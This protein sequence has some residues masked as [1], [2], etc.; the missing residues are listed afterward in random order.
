MSG[1]SEAR[2]TVLYSFLLNLLFQK[3]GKYPPI[4]T[5]PTIQGYNCK[6]SGIPALFE[7]F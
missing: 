2:D 1:V 5:I 6:E 4:P 3:K 7:G